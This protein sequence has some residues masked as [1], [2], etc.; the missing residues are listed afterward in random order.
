MPP[1]TDVTTQ[2]RHPSPPPK[3]ATHGRNPRPPP[4]AATTPVTAAPAIP[5]IPADMV[6]KAKEAVNN[7]VLKVQDTGGQPIFL[8]ILELLTTPEGTIYL[9]V[10]SLP[11]LQQAF[12]DTVETTVGQ[13]KSIQLFA[14]GAPVILVGTRKDEVT[15]GAEALKDLS[16]KLLAALQSQC[17]PAVKGL[18]RDSEGDLCFFAIENSKGIKGD[19]TIRQLVKAIERAARKL[20][21]MKMTLPP[22]W[23]RVYDELKK[24]QKRCLPL[25]EVRGVAQRFGM[26]SA[27]VSVD[28]ELTTM[29]TF[30]HSQN[31]LL[32]YDTPTLRDLVILDPKWVID[33]ATCF[34]R[35]YDLEDHTQNYLRMADLDNRA[36]REE[37]QAW[38]LLTKGAATLQRKVALTP[39]LSTH[40]L[41]HPPPPPTTS[42]IPPCSG[43]SQLLRILWS[44]QDFK[45]HYD[46]LLALM[47]R[48]S[49][50]IP[51][52]SGDYLIPALLP[53][54][55][56]AQP[57]NTP[58][59]GSAHMRIFF[60]LDGHNPGGT[61]LE[62]PPLKYYAR[63]LREGFLPV[64]VFHRL[65][66]AALSCSY[67]EASTFEPSLSYRRACIAM[68]GSIV[69]L[70][71][72][73]RE[74]S[75]HVTISGKDVRDGSA[76]A[77]V[78]G[79]PPGGEAGA[80]S[81]LRAFL[82]S[83]SRR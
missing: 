22:A 45:D 29:L 39:P 63:D 21:S 80:S 50:A 78:R 36:R 14:T 6:I 54:Q 23:L 25:E 8:S 27:D 17:G 5:E 32:W 24:R 28:E 2:V 15:G 11:K 34:I 49:L 61:S 47:V 1:P 74:S 42:N 69:T 12:E 59:P 43:C 76:A 56:A 55:G 65:C 83:A 53:A 58:E 40:H 3:A 41:H 30:F 82:P 33:A 64:G 77:S 62:A 19:S 75:I 4:K 31:A 70:D 48:F 71:F 10:F 26:P 13:L 38:D 67:E 20:P 68:H 44:S 57:A 60:F 81:I 73:E 7:I 72:K 79:A 37:P 18:E 35:Q 66:A 52:R 46:A 51:L 16:T 9:V